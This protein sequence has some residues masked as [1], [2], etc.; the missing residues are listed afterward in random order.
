MNI[1]KIGQNRLEMLPMFSYFVSQ[2]MKA[3]VFFS[4]FNKF[5]LITCVI[6][7]I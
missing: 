2:L 5:V 6:K 1:M 7:I 3:K 4:H